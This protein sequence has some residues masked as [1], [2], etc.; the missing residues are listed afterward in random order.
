MEKLQ[1]KSCY[2]I[3][4]VRISI[5]NED[6]AVRSI[7]G[8]VKNRQTGYVCIS[9]M[10]TV[11][12]ANKDNKYYE[13]MENSLMNTPDGTP[14]VWCGHWWGLKNVGRACGPHVFSRVLREND[15]EL[16][17]FFLGDTDET[18]ATLKK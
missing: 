17:H 14:L 15:N 4:R 11:S 6:D 18:L 3:G 7:I 2:R 9:N 12:I 16:K 10:R 1:D 13:V 8:F 5:T